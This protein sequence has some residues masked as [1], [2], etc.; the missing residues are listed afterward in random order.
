[1]TEPL[2]QRMFKARLNILS[3]LN[4]KDYQTEDLKA[5]QQDMRQSLKTDVRSMNKD[6]FIVRSEVEHVEHFQNDEAC[7][8]LDDLA[9]GRLREHISKLPNELESETLEAKLFDMLC[10][11]IELAVL[12][13]NDKAV[14]AYAK[15]VIEIASKLEIKENI[16]VVA[17]QIR[18]IQELQTEAYWE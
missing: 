3:L 1:T 9:I 8:N 6:N 7:D 15:K 18:L 10:Y 12:N 5:V 13:K 11:N 2:G 17:V 16:P 14:T 4:T